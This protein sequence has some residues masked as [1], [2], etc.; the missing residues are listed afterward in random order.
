MNGCFVPFTLAV[1]PQP[2]YREALI[3]PDREGG[4]DPSEEVAAWLQE[5]GQ[6]RPG[7]QAPAESSDELLAHLE[8]L[9]GKK[10]RT[11]EDIHVFLSGVARQA[12]QRRA[13]GWGKNALLGALLVI[14]ILQYYFIDVQLQILSQPSLTVFLPARNLGSAPPGER[15]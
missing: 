14:A 4:K 1:R 3:T 10:I 8:R 9:S 5:V 2:R 11:R 13:G 12:G 15:S 6:R 7:S